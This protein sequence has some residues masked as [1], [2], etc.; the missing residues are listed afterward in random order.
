MY[1]FV[2]LEIYKEM[3][4]PLL[5]VMESNGIKG[6]LLLAHEG[7]NAQLSVPAPQFEAFK[8]FLDSITFLKDVR[9][10]IAVEQDLKSFLKLTVK[11]RKKIVADGLNDNSFDVTDNE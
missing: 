11:V 9:L 4:Q 3:R 7:I 2:A 8:S 6:T 10:T 1:K 5:E